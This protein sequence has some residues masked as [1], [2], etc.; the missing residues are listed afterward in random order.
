[1]K[2]TGHRLYEKLVKSTGTQFSST[3][4][5]TEI[6]KVIGVQ[7][8]LHLAYL[9]LRRRALCGGHYL[10]YHSLLFSRLSTVRPGGE[11]WSTVV[12]YKIKV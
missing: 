2:E 7:L 6:K 1:M 9:L 12:L 8:V 4:K 3:L 10:L 5:T 11:E